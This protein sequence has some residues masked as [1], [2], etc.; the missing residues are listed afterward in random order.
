MKFYK[1]RGDLENSIVD[2]L[3]SMVNEN[4]VW[5]IED[6]EA[7]AENFDMTS[8]EFSDKYLEEYNGMEG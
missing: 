8:E 3:G 1:M 7:D 4:T 6:I 5:T 2:E